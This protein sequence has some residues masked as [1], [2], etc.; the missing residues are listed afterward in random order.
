MGHA[1]YANYLFWFEQARGAWCRARGFS[2]KVLEEMGYFL[3][4]VEAHVRYRGEVTYDDRI[5]VKVWLSET[6]R[7]AVRFD[8]QIVNDETGKLATEGYTWHVLM[9]TQRKAVS[10][11]PA[12]KEM[13]NRE[14]SEESQR[15]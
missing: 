6:K 2:Y 12:V 4:V 9:G 1:Y 3:P 5:T 7:A 10:I 13:L 8:Y 11:P 15:A 14:P